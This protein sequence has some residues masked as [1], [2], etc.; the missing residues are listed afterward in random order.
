MLHLST[1]TYN[2]EQV[3]KDFRQNSNWKHA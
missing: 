2:I 1:E 3:L